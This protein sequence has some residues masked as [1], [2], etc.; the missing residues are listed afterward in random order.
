[1]DS[2]N[3]ERLPV[4][5]EMLQ[6]TTVLLDRNGS[7]SYDTA[8]ASTVDPTNFKRGPAFLQLGVNYRWSSIVVDQRTPKPDIA[9]AAYSALGAALAGPVRAGDR[10]PD[11]SELCMA[12]AVRAMRLFNLFAPTRHTALV[13]ASKSADFDEAV[14]PFLQALQAQRTDTVR[15]IGVF[16]QGTGRDVTLR[17]ADAVVVDEAAHARTAYNV[18]EHDGI[19][20]AIVRPDGVV[21]GILTGAQGV[22]QYF[23]SIFP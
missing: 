19:V 1:M 18:G 12:G 6:H 23:S 20:V 3:A 17:G 4:I 9:E 15:T 7:E 16:P 22:N 13:F 14:G 2:Y 8:G 10:A 5:A 21:G 11:A